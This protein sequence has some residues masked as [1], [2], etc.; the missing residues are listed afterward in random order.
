MKKRKIVLA[1]LLTVSLAVPMPVG[2]AVEVTEKSEAETSAPCEEETS[3]EDDISGSEEIF[4]EEEGAFQESAEDSDETEEREYPEENIQKEELSGESESEETTDETLTAAEQGAED[5]SEIIGEGTCGENVT[6]TLTQKGTLTLSGTGPMED[7]S[8]WTSRPWD[9]ERVNWVIIEPGVT[10]IGDYSLFYANIKEISIPE[11]VTRIGEEAFGSCHRLESIELP[12]GLTE[13]GNGAFSECNRLESIELPSGLAEIK[14]D[15]FSGCDSLESIELPPGLT[16]IGNDVFYSCDLLDNVVIPESV[17]RIGD[18]AFESCKNLRNLT[19]QEG[20]TEIEDSAFEGCDSLEEIVL[21]FTVSRVGDIAFSRCDN[22]LSIQ[23]AE[24][25]QSYYSLDG[26][27]FS[28]DRRL[29]TCPAGKAGDYEVPEGTVTVGGRAFYGCNKLEAVVLSSAVKDVEQYWGYMSF[30]SAARIEVSE[31]NPYYS[32]LDGVLFDKEKT[33]LVACPTGRTGTYVIPDSVKVIGLYAFEE[34]EDLT[35]VTI[36][37]GVEVIGGRAFEG[38][39]KLKEVSIPASVKHIRSGAFYDCTRLKKIVFYGENPIP[40]DGSELEIF[41]Y[42]VADAY[43]CKEIW[44]EEMDQHY[45]AAT[46]TFHDCVPSP[47]EISQVKGLGYNAVEIS[48]EPVNN[49][50]GYRLYYQEEN[51]EP[52]KYITQLSGGENTSYVHTG[53][54]SGKEYTYYLR[55]YHSLDDGE[56]LFGAYSAGK[57]GKTEASRAKINKVQ[58]WGYNAL[59]ISWDALE[60]ADGYRLYY[61]E[62]GS[63]WKYVTQIADGDATSYVHTGRTTGKTYTYYVRGYRNVDGQKAFGSYSAGKSGKSLPRQAKITKAREG[64]NQATLSWDKVNGASGYRIYYK[65]SEN[66]KWHY[67]TQIGKGSTT[68]YTHKGIKEGK[69]YYYTMRAYRTVNGKKVF[70]AYAKWR[71]AGVTA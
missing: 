50:E 62:P 32:S 52:W 53:L 61:Q 3:E 17:T 57:T 39:K 29:V 7:F 4:T 34:C 26:A 43:Y 56:K 51:G 9:R 10:S 40:N 18:G 13:I 2:A 47:S 20:L 16:E 42:V 22:L 1:G 24:G 8:R 6:W 68:S 33:E 28:Q 31:E 12:S 59:K 44:G 27:L 11:S 37:N 19:L 36:P 66:G 64:K 23:V 46:L 14:N 30:R 58:S 55:A 60:S 5:T 70:G 41:Q 63:A 38:C 35:E 65:N 67:V 45:Q 25:N 54:Q 15:V 71:Q 48:W 49:A 69:D 21:P